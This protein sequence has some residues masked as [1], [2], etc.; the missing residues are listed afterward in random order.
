[1]GYITSKITICEEKTY[2]TN[3]NKITPS[4]TPADGLRPPLT[5]DV[6]AA[7]KVIF[8]KS[9]GNKIN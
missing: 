3:E 4:N 8:R 9:A 7:G 5:S 1:M 2:T 6:E